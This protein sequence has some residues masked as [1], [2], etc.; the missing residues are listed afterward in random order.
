MDIRKAF[1]AQWVNATALKVRIGS[2]LEN[3]VSGDKL[4][5]R[6][7]SLEA[8]RKE[9]TVRIYIIVSVFFENGIWNTVE[10]KIEAAQHFPNAAG[11][12]AMKIAQELDEKF[13]DSHFWTVTIKNENRQD[14][15]QLFHGRLSQ[16]ENSA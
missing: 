12:R 7:R 5:A 1:R 16:L 3:C 13:G 11:N 9:K 14:Y 2:Q 8:N 10:E 6:K 15:C 4:P